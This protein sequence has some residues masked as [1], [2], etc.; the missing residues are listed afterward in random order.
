MF[1]NVKDELNFTNSQTGEK[2]IFHR[3]TWLCS[4]F[5]ILTHYLRYKNEYAKKLIDEAKLCSDQS[6]DFHSVAMLCH[7][8][9]YHW[10][11]IIAHGEYYWN[12]GFNIELPDNYDEWLDNYR[13]TFNLN[14]SIC[15]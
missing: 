9:E 1:E 14:A 6:L 10:A 12:K 11:M 8:E 4:I 7:E 15:D 13:K 5:G 2:I 3:R